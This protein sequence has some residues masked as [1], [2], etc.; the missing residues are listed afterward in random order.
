MH[1]IRWSLLFVV[2][3]APLSIGCGGSEAVPVGS[4][5]DIAAFVAENPDSAAEVEDTAGAADAG[6]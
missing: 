5:D 1:K 2:L 6:N 3:L 4:Q